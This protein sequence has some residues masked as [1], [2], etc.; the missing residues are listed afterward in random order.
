MLVESRPDAVETTTGYA[1]LEESAAW[2]NLPGRGLLSVAGP[3][4]LRFL[5]AM[6]TADLRT[7]NPGKAAI[8]LYSTR[9]GEPSQTP[10]STR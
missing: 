8:R 2:L 5:N 9:E 4:R 6:V 3:D 1:A 7:L 10:P